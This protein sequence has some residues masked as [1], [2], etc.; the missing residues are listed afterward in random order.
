MNKKQII[1]GVV[2]TIVLL[3]I[4]HTYVN[5]KQEAYRSI[6]DDVLREQKTRLANMSRAVDSGSPVT[7]A[8]IVSD[9]VVEKRYRFD[10]LLSS[11]GDLTLIE[12]RELQGLFG[13]CAY[14]YATVQQ[15]G[16]SALEREVA[17]YNDQL[18]LATVFNKAAVDELDKISK[19]HEL[20]D[21]E[22]ERSN[23]Y[24]ALVV[25]QSDIVERLMAGDTINSSA[26]Q[27]LV[28]KGQEVRE[29]IVWIDQKIDAL[30]DQ[31]LET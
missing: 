29:N 26:V 19:W 20:V 12:L 6:S 27:T 10:E 14:Y 30:R 28:A 21:H 16:V 17:V 13:G 11:L 1:I 18:R 7:D 3:I 4:M 8:D 5:A 25:V 24:A 15:V 23:S 22:N 2:G 9:C 31:L